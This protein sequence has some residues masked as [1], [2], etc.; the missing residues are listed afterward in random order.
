MVK[1]L[2]SQQFLKKIYNTIYMN[3]GVIIKKKRLEE[4]LSQ[5]QFAGL[6]G[7]SRELISK[8]ETNFCEPN[9]K[10]KKKFCVFFNFIGSSCVFNVII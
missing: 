4:N 2:P 9:L 3:L 8:Y 6:F 7:V 5:K 1:T 10:N